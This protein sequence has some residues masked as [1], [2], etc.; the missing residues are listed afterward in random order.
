[1]SSN[2]FR[3]ALNQE[4]VV[5]VVPDMMT[6]SPGIVE[7]DPYRR[8]CY[9]PQEKHL[10]FFQYYTQQNCEV[11]CLTNHTLE[12]CGCVAYHMPSKDFIDVEGNQNF[13]NKLICIS[14]EN[15]TPICGPGSLECTLEAQSK[16][17]LIQDIYKA[18]SMIHFFFRRLASK[19][20]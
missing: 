18:T 8:Q 19:R 2:Y 14:G 1:M 9:F 3:V 15:S 7:Y 4:V 13:D 12:K 10:A 6:T 5:S 11:E 17:R 16:H 20:S